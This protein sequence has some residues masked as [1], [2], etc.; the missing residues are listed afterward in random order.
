VFASRSFF[1][2]CA[3]FASTIVIASTALLPLYAACVATKQ[4]H[5]AAEHAQWVADAPLRAAEQERR[6]L[7]LE[8][9][10][11][12]LPYPHRTGDFPPPPPYHANLD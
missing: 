1:R 8:R 4:A 10:A 7:Q 6:R 3:V 11:R 5:A 2:D 9:M 12:D